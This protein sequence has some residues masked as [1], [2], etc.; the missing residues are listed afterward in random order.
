[1]AGGKTTAAAQGAW[2]CFLDETGQSL[3]PPRART[4]GRRGRTPVVRVPGRG[5]N[6]RVSVVGMVCY[7]PGW[8]PRLLY[9][10]RTWRGG[11][12]QKGIGWADCRDLLAAAHAQLPGGR[13]VLVWDR[14]NIHR[15]AEMTTFLREHTGWVS[16]VLLP[17]YAPDL[18]PAEMG[19]PDCGV[20]RFLWS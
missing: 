18:N 2:I 17:A 7:R 14:V 12:G 4:W 3:R 9:R 16:T 13:L 6:G 11:G 5:G 15:Q 8:R 10:T 20:R 19:L 1:M